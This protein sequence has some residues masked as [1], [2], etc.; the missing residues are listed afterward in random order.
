M[1]QENRWRVK[2]VFF[3]NDHAN[4]TWLEFHYGNYLRHPASLAFPA[5]F[6]RIFLVH[7]ALDPA[8][9]KNTGESWRQGE[10]NKGAG[11]LDIGNVAR[12]SSDQSVC[13]GFAS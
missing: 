1:P 8:S 7:Q 11:L 9:E 6:P 2:A 5:L 12:Q 10:K 4:Q 13:A 3:S